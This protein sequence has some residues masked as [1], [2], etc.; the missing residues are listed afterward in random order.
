MSHNFI[1]YDSVMYVRRFV[2]HVFPRRGL[3]PPGPMNPLVPPL[4]SHPPKHYD[5]RKVSLPR[6][7]MVSGGGMIMN[8]KVFDKVDF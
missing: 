4:L 3:G 6:K 1:K 5:A 8:L 2:R 7:T